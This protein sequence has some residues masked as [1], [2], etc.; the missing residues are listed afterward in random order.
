MNRL[1]N[2]RAFILG[3]VILSAGWTV[4]RRD[5]FFKR[6]PGDHLGE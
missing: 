4:R 2:R 3:L 5:R 6:E 1:M